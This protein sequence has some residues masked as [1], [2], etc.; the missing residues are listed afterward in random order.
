[1]IAP[2]WNV[3]KKAARWLESKRR[4]IFD[5]E[6]E[7]I[8]FWNQELRF[9]DLS[10]LLIFYFVFK[11]DCWI[12]PFHKT[13]CPFQSPLP[14]R[15]KRE[16]PSNE[17]MFAKGFGKSWLEQTTQTQDITSELLLA[18]GRGGRSARPGFWLPAG[19]GRRAGNDPQLP[20][21]QERAQ[22][23]GAEAWTL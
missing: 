22:Q 18:E 13:V 19:V 17:L 1:M 4:E 7:W 2:Y 3:P 23:W 15:E 11:T 9:S 21:A 10:H 8:L 20:R 5:F 12:F 6:P 16:K 14:W